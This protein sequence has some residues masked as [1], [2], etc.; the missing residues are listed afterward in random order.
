TGG[1]RPGRGGGRPG[2]DTRHLARLPKT[3]HL[4]T[5]QSGTGPDTRQPTQ[6]PTLCGVVDRFSSV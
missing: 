5:P 2:A 6:Q 4:T 1:G 3:C